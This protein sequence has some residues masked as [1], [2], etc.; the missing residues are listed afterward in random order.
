MFEGRYQRIILC[1]CF[2]NLAQV[3]VFAMFFLYQFNR[4]YASDEDESLFV[5]SCGRNDESE[6]TSSRGDSSCSQ[7]DS[8][9]QE[10][11]GFFDG[12]TSET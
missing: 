10:K 4:Q 9:L 6:E 5:V 1:C 11:F 8:D 12:K 3:K 7:I 2:F